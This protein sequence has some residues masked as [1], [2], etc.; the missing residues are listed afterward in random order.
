MNGRSGDPPGSQ[1]VFKSRLSQRWSRSAKHL[2]KHLFALRAKDAWQLF[3]ALLVRER[4]AHLPKVDILPE[5]VIHAEPHAA[6]DADPD[7]LGLLA[8]LRAHI[9]LHTRSSFR[10]LRYIA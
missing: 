1:V 5:R 3:L 4:V 2:S 9:T 6:D 10:L 7:R 8:G